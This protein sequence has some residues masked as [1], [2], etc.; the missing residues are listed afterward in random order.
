M[1]VVNLNIITQTAKVCELLH[2]EMI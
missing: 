1:I 2:V